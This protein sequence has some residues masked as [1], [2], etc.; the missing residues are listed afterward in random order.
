MGSVSGAARRV[1]PAGGLADRVCVKV[2]ATVGAVFEASCTLTLTLTC[3][4]GRAAVI[5]P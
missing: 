1:W 2:L 5:D 4:L 3:T